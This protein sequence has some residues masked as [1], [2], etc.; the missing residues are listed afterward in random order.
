MFSVITH[1]VWFFGKVLLAFGIVKGA[2]GLLGGDE[3]ESA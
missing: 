2:S 1:I 3:Q